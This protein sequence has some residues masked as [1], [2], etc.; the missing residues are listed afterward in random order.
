MKRDWV[1]IPLFSFHFAPS[2]RLT[3]S[4]NNSGLGR[5]QRIAPSWASRLLI[6]REKKIVVGVGEKGKGD[7]EE[8]PFSRSSNCENY[9]PKKGRREASVVS[10]I[11]FFLSHFDIFFPPKAICSL[12]DSDPLS[13]TLPN[14]IFEKVF[15]SSSYPNL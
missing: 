11:G 15:S 2:D 4:R 3:L 10:P 14:A 12:G 9:S 5:V 13:S 8:N 7:L 6:P 1:S